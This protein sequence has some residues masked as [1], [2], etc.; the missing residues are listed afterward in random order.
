M[1]F[2][3]IVQGLK[4]MVSVKNIQSED[5]HKYIVFNKILWRKVGSEGAGIK[6][7]MKLER[8]E[9][10]CTIEKWV[11]GEELKTL[12]Y[13]ISPTYY[14]DL[15]KLEPVNIKISQEQYKEFIYEV[16]KQELRIGQYFCNKFNI[17]NSELFY[18]EDKN[19]AM[20]IIVRYIKF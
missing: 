5:G 7:A 17:D 6:Y 15:N 16:F 19:K 14:I 9:N 4:V 18:T 20:E 8:K 1:I 2:E 11:K 12:L 10:G 3:L 13:V